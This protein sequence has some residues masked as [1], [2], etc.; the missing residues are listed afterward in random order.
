MGSIYRPLISSHLPG[1]L[2]G[3]YRARNIS[4]QERLLGGLLNT[5]TSQGSP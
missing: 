5:N 2:Q 3:F 1:P 4:A